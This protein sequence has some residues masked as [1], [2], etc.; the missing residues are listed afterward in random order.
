MIHAFPLDLNIHVSFNFM[1]TLMKQQTQTNSRDIYV[2][3]TI[4]TAP[5]GYCS[6][7]LK[8]FGYP[9][10]RFWSYLMK[11]IPETRRAH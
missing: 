9:I 10:F 8:L 11:V 6:H 4:Q 3:F 2:H 5:V 7:N 1:E